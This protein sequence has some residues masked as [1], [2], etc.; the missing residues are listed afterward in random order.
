MLF[1]WLAARHAR[2]EFNQA[3]KAIDSAIDNALK[4]PQTRTRDLGGTLNTDAFGQHIAG[5]IG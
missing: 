1:E 2:P 3:A 5:Q 4:S